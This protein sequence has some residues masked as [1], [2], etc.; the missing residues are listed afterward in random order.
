MDATRKTVA[1]S[2]ECYEY[3]MSGGIAN[4]ATDV[5]GALKISF[6]QSVTDAEVARVSYI[7]YDLI[8]RTL[9]GACRYADT[10]DQQAADPDSGYTLHRIRF[11]TAATTPSAEGG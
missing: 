7:H 6:L 10:Q 1:G 5:I 11:N 4:T 2:R 8:F 3:G 9:A